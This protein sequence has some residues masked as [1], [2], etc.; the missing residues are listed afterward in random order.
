[1]SPRRF[2]MTSIGVAIAFAILGRLLLPYDALAATS[3]AERL[4]V[5]LLTLWTA[6]VM[7][8]CFGAA[9]LVSSIAPIGIRDVAEIGSVSA[10]V[11]ARRTS[12]R[13]DGARFHNFAGW[14]VATGGWLIILYFVIWL[15]TH[16]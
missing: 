4:R 14:S 2:W 1:M 7:A 10:A 3:A 12:R 9:G 13:R 6:G 8:I 16:T 11:E 5:W 15:V